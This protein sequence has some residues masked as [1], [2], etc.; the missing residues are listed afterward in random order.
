MIPAGDFGVAFL[1]THGHF[2]ALHMAAQNSHNEC[3]QVLITNGAEVN[4]QLSDGTTALHVAT[5]RYLL[6]E[7][8]MILVLVNVST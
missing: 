6:V 1:Q 3:L 2:T 8:M 7:A 4:A 5:R